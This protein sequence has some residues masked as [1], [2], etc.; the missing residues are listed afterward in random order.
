MQW[1][2]NRLEDST[3]ENYGTFGHLY[4]EVNLGD[5]VHFDGEGNDTKAKTIVDK[6]Q[7]ITAGWSKAQIEENESTED[8]MRP[9]AKKMEME[10]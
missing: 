6:V 2:D 10:L 7:E 1:T 3:W 5:K 4:N 8:E 9:K